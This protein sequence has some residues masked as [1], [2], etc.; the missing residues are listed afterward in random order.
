MLRVGIR[1]GSEGR[2]RLVARIDHPTTTGCDT[3]APRH[4]LG[5]ILY[6][7]VARRTGPARLIAFAVL[8]GSSTL[9]GLAASLTPDGRGFGSH[10]QL[11]YPPCTSV[12][13]FGYPCPTCG[14]TTS[15]AH[16][17]RGELIASFQAQPAGFLLGLATIASAAVSV[18]VL[19]TGKVWSVNWFR[20]S[21]ARLVA[22][23]L[24]L[25]VGGWAY[26]IAVGVWSGTF[27]VGR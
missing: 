17:V 2:T 18:S 3:G 7:S 10:Q 9:L 6:R 4:P 22:V 5:P 21:A 20:V 26:K 13:V 14:M 15:F 12:V 27:P 8:G 24:L 16:L 11:G 25:A 23:L 19:V 1:N